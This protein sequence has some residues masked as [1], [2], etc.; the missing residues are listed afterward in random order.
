M[1]AEVV[2]KF[3]LFVWS[4][5]SHAENLIYKGLSLMWIFLRPKAAVKKYSKHQS[6]GERTSLGNKKQEKYT[7]YLALD[8]NI[9]FL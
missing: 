7:Y 9:R 3:H 5:S 2:L 1:K 4:L 8:L 6:Y